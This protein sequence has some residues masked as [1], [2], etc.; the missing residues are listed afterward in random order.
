MYTAIIEG[1]PLPNGEKV[2]VGFKTPGFVI[3]G[4]G[5]NPIDTVSLVATEKEKIEAINSLGKGKAN[6]EKA[7]EL[8]SE[9]V[10]PGFIG[11]YVETGST[12][13]LFDILSDEAAAES[14][15]T[16]SKLDLAKE[17]EETDKL[18]TEAQ[19]KVKA[20]EAELAKMA[21]SGSDEVTPGE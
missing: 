18:L 8:T 13:G 21:T 10:L 9:L 15:I 19:E 4:R 6:Q 5:K 16:K 7:E 12:S 11:K 1:L 3:P 14:T 2:N 20:L 17:K